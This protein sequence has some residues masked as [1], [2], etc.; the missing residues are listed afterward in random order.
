MI[1]RHVIPWIMER[2]AHQTPVRRL[3]RSQSD[4]KSS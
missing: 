3:K 4:L 2:E 1:L